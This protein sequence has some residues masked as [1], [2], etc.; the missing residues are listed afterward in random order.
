MSTP[1]FEPNP[2][3]TAASVANR[4]TGWATQLTELITTKGLHLKT[5][6]VLLVVDLIILNLD[7]VTRTIFQK[8]SRS[9]DSNVPPKNCV[10]SAAVSVIAEP[11]PTDET[12][13]NA[14]KE[15][16]RVGDVC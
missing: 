13:S 1:G 5:T 6:Q 12:L 9:T 10:R 16:Q 14:S 3:G 8:I 7:Q 11:T 15:I 2:S 4:H